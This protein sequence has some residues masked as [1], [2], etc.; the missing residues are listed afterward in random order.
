MA[1][2]KGT[3]NDLLAFLNPDK[4]NANAFGYKAMEII[5]ISPGTCEF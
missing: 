4:V 2:V 5:S 3:D 1:K